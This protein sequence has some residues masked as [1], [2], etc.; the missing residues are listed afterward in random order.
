MVFLNI[1][2]E[3]LDV[4]A[5]FWDV[6]VIIIVTTTTAGVHGHLH[7]VELE[8]GAEGLHGDVACAVGIIECVGCTYKKDAAVG[9]VPV[10]SGVGR[11]EGNR[12][13]LRC[14]CNGV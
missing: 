14:D 2:Y 11:N 1:E 7:A 6:I 3:S 12:T 13:I 8:V 4:A 5:T 10:E 9:I